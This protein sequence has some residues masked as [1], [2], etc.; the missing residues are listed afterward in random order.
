MVTITCG[1]SLIFIGSLHFLNGSLDILVK[2]LQKNDYH[3]VSQKV[4]ANVMDLVK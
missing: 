4:N 1:N 3:H 2:N